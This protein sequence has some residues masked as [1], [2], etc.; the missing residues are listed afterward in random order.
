M[1]GFLIGRSEK[2]R[3]LQ[4][5]GKVLSCS[6]KPDESRISATV[7]GSASAPYVVEV[8]WGAEEDIDGICSCPVG[9][10]CKHV[11]AAIFE[12]LH[13]ATNSGTSPDKRPKP[14]FTPQVQT[15]LQ[16]LQRAT[17]P[18]TP[19]ESEPAPGD[20]PE[21]LVYI[22]ALE[23]A[24]GYGVTTPA[25]PQLTV[26]TEVVRKLGQGGYGAGRIFYFNEAFANPRPPHV[27]AVDISLLKRLKAIQPGDQHYYQGMVLIGDEGAAMLEELL[28]TGRCHWKG[29]GKKHPALSLGQPRLAKLEWRADARGLQTPGLDVSPVPTAI[30]PLVPPWYLDEGTGAC[31]PL[32]TGLP[33]AVAQAWIN[34]PALM[35]DQAELLNEELARRFPELEDSGAATD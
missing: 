5:A 13:L 10:N 20:E 34:A 2:G 18:P 19:P 25:E 15:W 24:M 22:L 1:N 23:R 14:K 4:R 28:R 12:A 9:F 35:P 29:S 33:P 6:V 7:I 8:Q 30:L 26:K 32:D 11:V 3:K 17:A 27:R 31:G 21:R 16:Q